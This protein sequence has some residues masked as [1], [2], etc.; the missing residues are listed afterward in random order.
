MIVLLHVLIGTCFGSFLQVVVSR[1]DWMHGR[2]RCDICGYVL[3]WYDLIPI[4]SYCFLRGRCRNCGKKISITHL[5]AEL[6][7]GIGFGI[8]GWLFSTQ[9]PARLIIL[10]L[11]IIAI[12]ISAIMDWKEQCFYTIFADIASG[13]VFTVQIT[14]FLFTRQYSESCIYMILACGAAM[15]LFL[16]AYVDRERL[17]GTGDYH[18]LFLLLLAV[19]I[20]RLFLCLICGSAVGLILFAMQAVCGTVQ[21]KLAF[22][23]LLFYGYLIVLIL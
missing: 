15:L 16:C 6:I 10:Y 21:R 9:D 17:I 13:L 5:Y 2:S 20:K 7:M 22:V 1:P 3:H 14:M 18:I 11:S 12:G 19:G 23:P 8:I 4:L